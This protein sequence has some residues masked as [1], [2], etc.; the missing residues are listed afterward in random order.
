MTTPPPT[1]HY[2]SPIKSPTPPF[3]KLFLALTLPATLLPFLPFNY[4]L[5]FCGMLYDIIITRSSLFSI[6][7]NPILSIALSFLL[8]FPILLWKA[9]LL[10]PAR[11]SRIDLA[12]GLPLAILCSLPHAAILLQVIYLTYNTNNLYVYNI[13]SLSW[14]LLC[15]LGIAW[16]IRH[17]L[18]GT[19]HPRVAI[20]AWLLCLWVTNST[21]CLYTFAP[22]SNP[23]SKPGIGYYLTLPAT[24]LAL[25]ELLLLTLTATRPYLPPPPSTPL[26]TPA[27]IP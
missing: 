14:L 10:F 5:S 19:Y 7:P 16:I 15:S 6:L 13:I 21:L 4:D 8:I 22:F 9:F 12:L 17:L 24:L 2:A 26:P 25:A 3:P 11:P 1:L 23:Y 20:Y 27:A 18:R